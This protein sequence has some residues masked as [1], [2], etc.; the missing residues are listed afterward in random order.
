[1]TSAV[2]CCDCLPSD[3][4]GQPAKLRP[5]VLGRE[6]LSHVDQAVRNMKCTTAVWRT[7]AA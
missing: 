6:V 3:L 1:M 7:G 2:A 4:A 5:A